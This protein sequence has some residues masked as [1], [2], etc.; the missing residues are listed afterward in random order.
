MRNTAKHET[1]LILLIKVVVVP[2]LSVILILSNKKCLEVTAYVTHVQF[3]PGF[4][5]LR[6]MLHL[7]Y[8]IQ[9]TVDELRKYLGK[10]SGMRIVLLT[11]SGS[12]LSTFL[13]SVLPRLSNNG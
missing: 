13:L 9:D 8:K 10:T 3:T 1:I 6:Y 5:C 4:L 12:L 2:L 7:L 11:L